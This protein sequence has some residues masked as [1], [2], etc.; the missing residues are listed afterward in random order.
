MTII[1]VYSRNNNYLIQLKP[2]II[3]NTA[4]TITLKVTSVKKRGKRVTY[5]YFIL[6][7]PD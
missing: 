3:K 4:K 7:I 5:L 1:E 6:L 2:K